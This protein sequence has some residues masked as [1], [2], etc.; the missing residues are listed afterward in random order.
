MS[1]QIANVENEL[2]FDPKNL[3]KD[4]IKKYLCPGATDQ[5]LTYGLQIAKTFNLN[6]LKRE[7]YFVKY[8]DQPMQTL[9]G[10]EVY[11]KRAERSGKYDGLSVKSEG[12]VEDKTLKAIVEVYKKGLSHPICH[13]IYYIEYVQY[14]KDGQ[15]NKFWKEKPV[16][17]TKKVAISQAF[18]LAF[19]DEFDGM[20]YT[21]DEV[22]DT[23]KVVDIKIE[24]PLVMPTKSTEEAK[25]VT[26]TM[27]KEDVV[28]IAQVVPET[29]RSDEKKDIVESA[30]EVF[31]GKII[32]TISVNEETDLKKLAFSKGYKGTKSFNEFL[33]Y[34]FEI[35]SISMIPKDRLKEVI[36]KLEGVK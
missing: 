36:K 14:R 28:P 30:K 4:T 33:T 23:E 7:I 12:K 24:E 26:K 2:L 16:T 3:T 17:M 1:N 35:R 18:R 13:E 29:G 22:V 19:P 5:E 11:L 9:T 15:I 10:Y 25:S 6:P 31:K 20:P 27:I 21:A 8:G 32:E 34:N